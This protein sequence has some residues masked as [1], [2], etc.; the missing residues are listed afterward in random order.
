MRA[1]ILAAGIGKRLQEQGKLMPKCFVQVGGKRLVDLHLERLAEC[2]ITEACFVVG[3]MAQEIRS[4][5][6]ADTSGVMIRFIENP[7]YLKGNIL[8]AYAARDL[9]DE[10]FILM[11]A[12]VAYPAALLSRLIQ[13]PHENCLLLDENFNNDAE[14]MKLGADEG[15]RVWEIC[16][17]LSRSWAVQ[18]E[19][20][21]F[22]R[23]SAAAGAIFREMLGR[24]IAAG[25]EG[26]EYEEVL[27]MLMKLALIRFEYVV[28]LP[29]TEIDFPE[30]LQKANALFARS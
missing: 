7:D 26:L 3:Y 12:D 16:R 17:R 20:V 8:S 23:C 14:E 27:N 6:A 15:G 13:S 28:G 30:D 11:D 2:G 21:G 24:T 29:W 4:H 10:P 9:F 18:G 5:L 22:F 1:I 25:G 19:G